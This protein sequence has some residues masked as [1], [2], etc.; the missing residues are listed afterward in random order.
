MLLAATEQALKLFHDGRDP[1]DGV[2]C[3]TENE[4]L[5]LDTLPRADLV[6]DEKGTRFCGLELRVIRTVLPDTIC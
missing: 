4:R 1:I 2:F 5:L 6:L 3:V